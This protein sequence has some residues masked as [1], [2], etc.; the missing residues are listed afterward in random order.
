MLCWRDV[1]TD[2]T[3]IGQ[4][5]RKC[6]PYMR[7]VF[8]T[9]DQDEETLKRQVICLTA[10]ALRLCRAILDQ[11]APILVLVTTLPHTH[12]ALGIKVQKRLVTI[13]YIYITFRVCISTL[14]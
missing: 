2:S 8:V 9:G 1:P 4:V 12:A 13:L 14:R 10:E 3:Q 11:L 5:A 6:E 7:Q